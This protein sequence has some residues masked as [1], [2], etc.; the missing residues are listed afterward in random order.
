MPGAIAASEVRVG[1]NGTLYIAPGGT[2]GPAN[3]TAPWSGFTNLGYLDEEGAKLARTLTT[4][5]V[6]A[7]QTISTIRYIP[8]EVA[9]VISFNLLQFNKDT[10]PFYLGGGAI[11]TQGG[12]SFKYSVSSAPTIDERVLG[13][14]WLDGAITSRVIIGRGMVTESGETA[15]GRS[16]PI[17][18]PLSFAA[19]APSSGTELSYFLTNDTAFA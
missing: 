8:T 17:K 12:G 10:L 18:L 5:Q 7:W 11:V 3:I 19:M 13:L 2:A 9:F 4:E 15:I 1:A 16:A 6:K 14:E